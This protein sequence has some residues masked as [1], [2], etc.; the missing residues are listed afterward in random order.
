MK[1]LTDADEEARRSIAAVKKLEDRL[2]EAQQ[3]R[4][5]EKLELDVEE[6]IGKL[7]NGDAVRSCSVIG[8]SQQLADD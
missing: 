4:S 8:L 6:S 1:K 3:R 5:C 2:E 7:S